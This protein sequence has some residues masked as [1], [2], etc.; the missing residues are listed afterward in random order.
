MKTILHMRILVGRH[1]AARRL[2]KKEGLFEKREIGICKSGMRHGDCRDFAEEIVD[3]I[4]S[5]WPENEAFLST[6]RLLRSIAITKK[7]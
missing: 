4:L 7:E 3:S 6:N 1:L 2:Q 5:N